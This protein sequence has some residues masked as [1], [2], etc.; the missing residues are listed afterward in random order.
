MYTSVTFGG[1]RSRLK[2]PG[3][4][5]VWVWVAG[6]G[7]TLHVRC[8]VT[9]CGRRSTSATFDSVGAWLWVAG[10][11][12]GNGTLQYDIA[13]QAQHYLVAGAVAVV[14]FSTKK[15]FRTTNEQVCIVW[16]C[17][18]IGVV[19]RIFYGGKLRC[20]LFQWICA[21]FPALEHV[22]ISVVFDVPVFRRVLE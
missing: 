8:S 6:A 2:H 22:A 9:L 11:G 4:V 10:A 15:Y 5:G 7:N 19:T 20:K 13:R 16:I 1:R 17:I 18:S 12:K 21:C 14:Q 3:S